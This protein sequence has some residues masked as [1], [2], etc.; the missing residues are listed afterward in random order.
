MLQALHFIPKLQTG[1][2]LI[3]KAEGSACILKC[4]S[5]CGSAVSGQKASDRHGERWVQ[6]AASL[7]FVSLSL[8]F[9]SLGF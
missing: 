4:K 9:Q 6:T 2:G 1:H 5:L 3:C 8:G 7:S